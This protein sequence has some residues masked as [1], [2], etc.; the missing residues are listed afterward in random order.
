MVGDHGDH[1]KRFQQVV[2]GQVA[3][4]LG[5]LHRENAG[6]GM[7]SKASLLYVREAAIKRTNR[8]AM[9]S[10]RTLFL[11]IFLEGYAVLSLEL[12]SIR[13]GINFIGSNTDKIAIIIAAVLIPL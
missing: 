4:Q 10:I 5:H 11:I 3:R 1:G 8:S 6:L 13:Q 7:A 12:L 2:G 9:P